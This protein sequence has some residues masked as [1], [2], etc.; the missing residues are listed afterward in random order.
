MLV[1]E[2][3]I[4]FQIQPQ[5]QFQMLAHQD[6]KVMELVIVYHKAYKFNVNQ[7]M[8]LMEWED[9]LQSSQLHHQQ[10]HSK[11]LNQVAQMDNTLMEMECAFQILY[12]F[13]VLLDI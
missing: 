5:L 4:A 6:I 11:H 12:K 10:N 3:E 7:D 13:P 1:M 2:M 9:V 8:S